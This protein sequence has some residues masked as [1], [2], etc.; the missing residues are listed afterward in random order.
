M[1]NAVRQ[2][3]PDFIAKSNQTV[4][5]FGVGIEGRWESPMFAVVLSEYN[6]KKQ[7]GA[8]NC[9][10]FNRAEATISSTP[11]PVRYFAFKAPP[12]NYTN[13]AF[14]KNNTNGETLA[15]NVAEGSISYLGDFIYTS[16]KVV[17]IRRNIDGINSM[18]PNI[19]PGLA[20]K[21]IL[22]DATAVQPPKQFVCTP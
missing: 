5:V 22:A 20:G 14:Y 11:G 13:S 2:I 9:F 21:L 10:Q 3:S 8:G 19:F 4:L 1:T 18:L 6:I 12:G 17:E 15:F 16:A 7:D